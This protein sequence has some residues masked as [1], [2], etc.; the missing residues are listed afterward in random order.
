MHSAVDVLA[1]VVISGASRA[2]VHTGIMGAGRRGFPER[3]ERGSGGQ[4]LPP[5]G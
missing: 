4:P 3:V 2:A 5:A 1:A